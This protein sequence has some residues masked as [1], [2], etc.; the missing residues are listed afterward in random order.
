MISEI[1]GY[2]K[3]PDICTFTFFALRAFGEIALNCLRCM[4]DTIVIY[5]NMSFILVV[6]VNHKYMRDFF[7]G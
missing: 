6:F 3:S 7:C 4:S 2:D 5:L 1:Y